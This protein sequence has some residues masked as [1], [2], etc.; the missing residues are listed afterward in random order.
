M[1][2]VIKLRNGSPIST[3]NFM[4]WE[5]QVVKH[6]ENCTECKKELEFKDIVD[7]KLSKKLIASG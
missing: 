4:R 3:R 2:N 6:L 1:K 7:A 5:E